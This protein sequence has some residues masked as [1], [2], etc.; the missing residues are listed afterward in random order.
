MGSG[1]LSSSSSLPSSVSRSELLVEGNDHAFRQLVHD[2]L[3]F[4]AVVQEVRNRLGDL[5][6]LSGAQYTILIAIARLSE[7]VADLGVNQLAIH[8]H[9]SGAF[10]TIEVNALVRAGLVKKAVNVEDRRRVVLSLTK[11][12]RQILQDLGQVQQPVNDT[13]FGGLSKSEFEALQGI[14]AGLAQQAP[15]VFPI[16][17]AAA[18]SGRLAH[19]LRHIPSARPAPA[20][21]RRKVATAFR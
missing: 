6:G 18:K 21:R 9:L 12:G 10:V 4:G 13:L 5:I 1:L 15:Q 17:D 2:M 16:I 14:M 20:K 8:L 11:K 7:R 3:A 19:G